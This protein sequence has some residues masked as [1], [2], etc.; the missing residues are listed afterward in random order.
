MEHRRRE[1]LLARKAAGAAPGSA[2][3]GRKP[4][5]IEADDQ[6]VS[7]ARQRPADQP[8]FTCHQVDEPLVRKT[9]S[10]VG[11]LPGAWAAPRKEAIS[12]GELRQISQFSSVQRL[13]KDIP[14][15]RL[16]PGL[17]EKIPRFATGC[18]LRPP[19]ERQGSWHGR[20]RKG[21]ECPG[22]LS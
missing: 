7:P 19:V 14:Q 6:Y 11:D 9:A 21:S 4:F 22:Q 20:L 18:S 16:D 10:Q 15:L 5:R 1:Y 12:G 2:C 3:Q 17:R 8:G 13:R